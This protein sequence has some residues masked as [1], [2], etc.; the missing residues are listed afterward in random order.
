MKAVVGGLPDVV[1][2]RPEHDRDLLRPLEAV[3]ARARLVDHHQR[4]HPHVALRMPLRLLR[5]ADE[6][7]QLRKQLVDDAEVEGEREA[8]RRSAGEEQQLLDL[9]PDALGRKIVEGNVSTQILRCGIHLQPEPCRELDSAEHAQA[10]LDERF[11]I[12]G[13]KDLVLKQVLPPVV[14][15]DDVLPSTDPSASR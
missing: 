14:G 2:D 1:H 13:A 15:V 10:V 7:L 5:A 12:N 11:G 8:D 3:D 9:A 4:V 6:R